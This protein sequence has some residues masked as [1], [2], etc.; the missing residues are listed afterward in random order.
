MC[1]CVRVQACAADVHSK[2][3]VGEFEESAIVV[4]LIKSLGSHNVARGLGYMCFRVCAYHAG[5][6]F[7]IIVALLYGIYR[8]IRCV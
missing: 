1:V 2:E 6:F 5:F 3:S 8:R 4:R 7:F